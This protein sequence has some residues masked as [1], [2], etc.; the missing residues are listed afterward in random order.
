MMIETETRAFQMSGHDHSVNL[1]ESLC[2]LGCERATKYVC[3]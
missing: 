3:A 2:G 1:F